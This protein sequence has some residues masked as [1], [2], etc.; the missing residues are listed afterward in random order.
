MENL[1]NTDAMKQELMDIVQ[2][3]INEYYDIDDLL[4]I[5]KEEGRLKMEVLPE[6][7]EVSDTAVA[8]SLPDLVC[9]DA[10]GNQIPDEDEISAIADEWLD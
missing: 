7:T 8:Y 10:E 3:Y 5:D 9:F 4:I 2:D 1:E 6:D